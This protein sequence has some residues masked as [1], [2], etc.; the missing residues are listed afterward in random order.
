M[1]G[2]G[3]V[4]GMFAGDPDADDESDCHAGGQAEDV[5]K[6][7]AAVL[8]ELTQGDE[9]IVFEHA[10][11][12]EYGRSVSRK[13]PVFLHVNNQF[14][15]ISSILINCPVP[16]TCCSVLYFLSCTPAPGMAGAESMD[17]GLCIRVA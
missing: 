3:L 13:M 8:A 6:G 7:V 14:V 4:D 12:L 2:I 17:V 15:A 10:L 16:H 1:A 11:V 5:D 9:E